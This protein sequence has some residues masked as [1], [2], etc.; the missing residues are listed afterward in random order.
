MAQFN[1]VVFCK[2]CMLCMLI[3]NGMHKN[4]TYRE[5]SI[6]GNLRERSMQTFSNFA[7]DMSFATCIY[8]KI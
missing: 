5:R 6:S 4:Q 1:F 7:A 3:C 2:V 8:D